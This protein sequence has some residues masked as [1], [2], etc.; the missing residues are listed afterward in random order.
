MNRPPQSHLPQ[1]S[2]ASDLNHPQIDDRTGS[3]PGPA[4]RHFLKI[5]AGGALMGWIV[6]A[7]ADLSSPAFSSPEVRPFFYEV[8]CSQ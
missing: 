8:N 2:F 5:A 6:R 4:R 7:G 3:R 1:Q